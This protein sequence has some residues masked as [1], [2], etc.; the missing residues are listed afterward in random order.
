MSFSVVESST[1]SY[2]RNVVTRNDVLYT[3]GVLDIHETQ[4]L[5]QSFT[6]NLCIKFVYVAI[7]IN[8]FLGQYHTQFSHVT[9]ILSS[10]KYL[11]HAA[12]NYTIGCKDYV[13]GPGSFSVSSDQRNMI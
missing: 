8:S 12:K 6:L 10:H 2:V 13:S 5:S 11:G 9:I 3:T 7:L 4:H 1:A